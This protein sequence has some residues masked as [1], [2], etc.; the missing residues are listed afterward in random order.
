MTKMNKNQY[1][2]GEGRQHCL[3]PWPSSSISVLF[4]FNPPWKGKVASSIF[5]SMTFTTARAPLNHADKP[6]SA[7]V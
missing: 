4:A 5:N 6:L 7:K 3:Q 1:L 2:K